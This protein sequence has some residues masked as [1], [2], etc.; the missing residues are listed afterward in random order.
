MSNLVAI[1]GDCH[2]GARNNSQIF[3]D[4]SKEFFTEV[5]FPELKSRG[6]R[7]I[8]QVG[9]LF[10]NRKA[11]N[12]GILDSAQQYLFN[13]LRAY[14]FTTLVG[15]HDSYFKNTLVVNS[16]ELFLDPSSNWDFVARPKA[17]DKYTL[18]PWIC[19][20]NYEDTMRLLAQ[21]T[22]EY[23]FGHL[24][25]SGFKNNSHVMKD[26]LSADVFKQFKRVFT[27]HY[28]SKQCIGNIMYVGTPYELSWS[29]FGE[30]KGFH[31]LDL[32]T[33]ELE[34]IKNP[35][36]MHH[37]I[38]YSAGQAI[39]LPNITGKIV[40]VLV[41]EKGDQ[42]LFDEF[43]KYLSE[44]NPHEL[45]ISDNIVEYD[46]TQDDIDLDIDSTPV[47]I[48]KYIANCEVSLDKPRLNG[49]FAELYSEAL[50]V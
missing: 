49:M 42:K 4:Q 36:V 50:L 47:I 26:G 43:I 46:D 14:D 44:Q 8:I 13:Q 15:N 25:L 48:E 24:E 33:G 11:M 39:N 17:T 29:D 23:C 20:A 37:K 31:I 30:D 10:D 27:G 28:H 38:H 32:D 21:S 22:G 34:F 3:D 41:G 19:E 12:L 35:N 9:D 16:Q 6:V 1:L 40:R 7:T 45:K 18:V 5:F 2:I